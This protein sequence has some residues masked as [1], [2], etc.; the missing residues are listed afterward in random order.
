MCV[1]VCVWMTD[2]HHWWAGGWVGRCVCVCGCLGTR[3]YLPVCNTY[4]TES[5]NN[6]A[7][8][9]HYIRLLGQGR[10]VLYAHAGKRQTLQ[11]IALF[12][13]GGGSVGRGLITTSS[14]VHVQLFEGATGCV[15][16]GQVTSAASVDLQCW[17]MLSSI[18]IPLPLNIKARNR[19]G[20]PPRSLGCMFA[21]RML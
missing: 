13:F 18:Q 6:D 14:V 10:F 2:I 21:F 7:C 17:C 16:F 9:R 11:E 4:T 12:F 1:C 3:N 8:V 20:K 19:D 5:D 15:G